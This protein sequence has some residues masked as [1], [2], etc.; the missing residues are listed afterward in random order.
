MSGHKPSEARMD[1]TYTQ[2]KDVTKLEMVNCLIFFL[3]P[4]VVLNEKIIAGIWRYGWRIRQ[5]YDKYE[6]DQIDK[7]REER[8]KNRLAN[9]IGS[10]DEYVVTQVI[11]IQ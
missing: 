10:F 2:V 11:N 4:E 1:N 8:R 9:L 7:E 6:K 3:D 5:F